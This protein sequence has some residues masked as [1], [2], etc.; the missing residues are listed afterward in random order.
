MKKGWNIEKIDLTPVVSEE[1]E[2]LPA[3]KKEK[4]R[5]AVKKHWLKTLLI[6]PH[7]HG[8]FAAFS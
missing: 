1:P 6:R 7:S 4:L 5:R 2:E 8:V 3:G